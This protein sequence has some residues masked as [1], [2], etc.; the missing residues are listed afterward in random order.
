MRP[1][2]GYRNPWL[3]GIVREKFASSVVMWTRMA[4]DWAVA[5]PDPVIQRL[6]PTVGGDIVVL[7]DGDHRALEGR[8]EHILAALEYWLPRWKDQGLRFSNMDEVAAKS[9]AAQPA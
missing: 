2:Y 1:P 5:T 8:R 9:G 7:H 6:R 3:D 4:R